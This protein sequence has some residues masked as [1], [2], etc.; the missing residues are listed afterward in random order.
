MKSKFKMNR[1]LLVSC[2]AL[3]AILSVFTVSAGELAE[4]VHI[5][6][7]G[8][9]VSEGSS[10]VL[11]AFAGDRIP[12]EVFFVAADNGDSTLDSIDNVKI[13]VEISGLRDDI[14]AETSRFDVFENNSYVKLLTLEI[15]S[16]L[17]DELTEGSGDIFTLVV[18]IKSKG[19]VHEAE[20]N[21]HLQRESFVVE[22]LIVQVAPSVQAGENLEVDIVA[23]NRGSA[24]LNDVI[25]LISVPALGIEKL[26]FIDDLFPVD[27]GD[28]DDADDDAERLVLLKIPENALA[29]VYTLDI[30]I[31]NPDAVS[32]VIRRQFV[33]ESAV[34]RGSDV[35]VPLSAKTARVGE[36]LTFDLVI[37]NRGDRTAVY[38]IIP[39]ATGSIFVSA[40]EPIVV[41]SGDSSRT[42]KI[43]AVAQESGNYPI[44]VTVNS[45]GQLVEKA[46]LSAQVQRGT[47]SIAARGDGIVVLTIVLAIVFVVLLVILLVLLTRKPKKESEESYY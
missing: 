37:L 23:K 26:V 22:P 13:E 3:F 28:E 39:E 4:Q 36:E 25:A 14:E 5:N 44:T 9:R 21:L 10:A 45:E 33:V 29:G 20:F 8:I 38:E 41:V 12:L 27:R 47:T 11:T 30:V 32:E 31:E 40:I 24:K 42:V 2:V 19:L 15:P 18:S 6:F 17:E 1:S 35:L 46:T 43:R 34:M 7:N 16:D